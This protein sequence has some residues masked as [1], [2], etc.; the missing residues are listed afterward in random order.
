MTSPRSA[1]ERGIAS[2]AEH[3]GDAW[4]ERAAHYVRW[5]FRV[6]RKPQTMEACRLWAYAHGLEVPPEQRA[7]GSVTQRAMRE[8]VIKPT[9]R[10]AQ[11]ASSHLS[12]KMLYRRK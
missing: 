4:C 7:W 10:F 9:G 3:A 2:S 1:K 8:D 6:Y 5:F 11:A 12:P